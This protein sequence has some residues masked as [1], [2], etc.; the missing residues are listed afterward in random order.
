[1]GYVFLC[2]F[3]EQCVPDCPIDYNSISNRYIEGMRYV[4]DTFL[5]L[6]P[7]LHITKF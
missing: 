3:E 6:S 5:L 2:H 1:M 4:E 7:E